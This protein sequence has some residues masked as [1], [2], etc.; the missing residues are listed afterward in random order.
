[1]EANKDNKLI[2]IATF[3]YSSEMTVILAKLESEGI[4]YFIKDE[5]TI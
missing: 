3:G 1:M 5:L 2:T 4:N